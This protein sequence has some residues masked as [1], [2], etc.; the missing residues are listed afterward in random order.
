MACNCLGLLSPIR[1]KYMWT[2]LNW[3]FSYDSYK[4]GLHT[5]EQQ[6]RRQQCTR[7]LAVA[8]A[9]MRKEISKYYCELF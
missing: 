3:H 1:G 2:K 8:H 9:A 7:S 4:S 5:E 6:L